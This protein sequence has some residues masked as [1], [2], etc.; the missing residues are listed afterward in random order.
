MLKT[1]ELRDKSAD[2]LE[3]L[4]LETRN[5]L[6]K[7]RNETQLSKESK[8]RSEIRTKRKDIAR[9]LTVIN[10]KDVLSN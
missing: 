6:F 10:E 2:E 5:H 3:V 4:L 1:N 9:L 7:L 8:N